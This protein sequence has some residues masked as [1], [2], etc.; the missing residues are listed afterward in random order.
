[1]PVPTD[2]DRSF[3]NCAAL[4]LLGCANV[5]CSSAPWIL[6][7]VWLVLG[8]MLIFSALPY[9]SPPI[10]LLTTPVLLLSYLFLYAVHVTRNL[11]S[12]QQ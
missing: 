10:A 12:H 6:G 11:R 8:T 9:L 7:I 4:V 3:K 5:L 2:V 1:M